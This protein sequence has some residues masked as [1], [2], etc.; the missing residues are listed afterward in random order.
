M[1]KCSRR[2]RVLQAQGYHAVKLLVLVA[3]DILRTNRIQI[4]FQPSMMSRSLTC[5][6]AKYAAGPVPTPHCTVALNLILSR[7]PVGRWC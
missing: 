1:G 7:S 5:V 3:L 6:C 2:R 4:G